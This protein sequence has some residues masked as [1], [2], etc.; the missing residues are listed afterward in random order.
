MRNRP[1]RD[2]RD[3]L[4]TKPRVSWITD[5]AEWRPPSNVQPSS[6]WC[7]PS[8]TSSWVSEGLLYVGVRL[9]GLGLGLGLGVDYLEVALNA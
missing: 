2:E 1:L 8:T 7:L 4:K 9:L 3:T 5:T 6:P